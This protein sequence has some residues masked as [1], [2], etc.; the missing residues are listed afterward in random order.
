MTES[1]LR[2]P[3]VRC[4][5]DNLNAPNDLTLLTGPGFLWGIASILIVLTF[6]GKYPVFLI[7]TNYNDQVTNAQ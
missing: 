7:L 3:S 5:E 4:F 6:L 2:P 1:P